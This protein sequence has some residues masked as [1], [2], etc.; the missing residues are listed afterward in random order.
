MKQYASKDYYGLLGLTYEA[1]TEEIKKA[2][3]KATVKYH[4]DVNKNGEKI[5]MEIKEA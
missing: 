5:F 2:F 4:P 1:T 3:R